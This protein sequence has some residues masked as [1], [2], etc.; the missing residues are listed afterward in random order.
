[1]S[2]YDLQLYA[3]YA[4]EHMLPTRRAEIYSAQTAYIV[5][6]AMGG[7]KGVF[8]DF[9]LRKA[10]ETSGQDFFDDFDPV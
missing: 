8:E 3:A 10:D 6:Q 9:L 7:Y 2:D 1:M 5:A 4:A